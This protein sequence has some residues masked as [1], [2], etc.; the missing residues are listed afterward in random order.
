MNAHAGST[1][2]FHEPTDVAEAIHE[3]ARPLLLVSDV[4]GTLSPI[5]ARP[6]QARL[7]SGALAAV[8]ALA[9]RPDVEVAV[10]SGRPLADLVGQ[11]GF[12]TTLHL[13]GSHGAEMDGNVPD[14]AEQ[15]R[16]DQVIAALGEIAGTVANTR[17]EVK[18]FAAALHVRNATPE[19][20][21]RALTMA[22]ARFD[23]A[24]GI[25]VHEGHQVYEV[26]VRHVDKAVALAVLRERLQPATVAFFGDDRSDET[27]FAE[28][29][30]DDI[31]VKVGPGPT[32]ARWRLATPIDVVAT[33]ALVR[34]RG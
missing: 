30:V 20:A 21:S 4:D 16:R 9:E 1:D 33:L 15:A 25:E 11:F 18:P 23:A 17:V 3:S 32:A 10:L 26:A 19:D 34:D 7:A 28:L 13:I 5:A 27:A 8:L 6:E 22:R 24:D 14:A 29:G 2:R 31:G 12:P